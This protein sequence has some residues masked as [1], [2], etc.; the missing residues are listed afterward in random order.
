MARPELS[1]IDRT[2]ELVRWFL[3]HLAKFPRSHRYGLGQAIEQT[4]YAVLESLLRAKYG[5]AGAKAEYLGEAN[6]Q[7]EILRMQC[8]LAHELAIMSHGSQE[9]AVR[10]LTE[11]GG[12]VGG[13]LRQ[14]RQKTASSSS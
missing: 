11:I 13:W 9:Y 3:G 1:V 8:R 4:L 14:Q 12:M 2:Y 6:V 5:A 10:E 7:L